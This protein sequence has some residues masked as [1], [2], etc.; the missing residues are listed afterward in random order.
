MNWTHGNNFSD[1]DVGYIGWIRALD[2]IVQLPVKTAVPAHGELGDVDLLRSETL[3]RI[4]GIR[5]SK[6]SKLEN[7]PRERQKT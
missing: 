1:Q 3:L 5:S 7:L 2:K 6:I 4:C